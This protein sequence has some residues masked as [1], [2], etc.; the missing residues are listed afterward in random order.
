MNFLSWHRKIIEK[1]E[2]HE[3]F[4]TH[5]RSHTKYDDQM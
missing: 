2:V 1:K 4:E 5:T 3:R